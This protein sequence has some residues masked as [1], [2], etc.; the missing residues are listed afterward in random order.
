[1]SGRFQQPQAVLRGILESPRGIVIFALDREYRYLAFNENHARTMKHI[2]GVDIRVGDSMLDLISRPDDREKARRNFDRALGGESFTVIEEYGDERIH[3]NVYQ[4]VYSPICDD[5]ANVIGLTVY[6]TDITE[7]RVAERELE[8]YRNRLEELVKQRTLELE[9][10]HAQLLH[11]QKLESLGVLAGGIAHDFNNLLAV[12]LARTELTTSLLPSEHAARAHVDIV[13]DTALEARMLTKQL[14]GYSGKG[15]FVVQNVDLSEMVEGMSQ[16]LRASI[17][18]SICLKFELGEL[19]AA[20]EVDVTQVRQ[21]LLNLATNAAEAIGDGP[22]VVTIRTRKIDLDENE[23]R[24]A[25]V[26]S[27]VL[28]GPHIALEVEDNGSGMDD[29]IRSKLFDPFF[30]TKFSGRGLGLAA[31][32]GIVTSHRGTILLQTEPGKGSSFTVIFPLSRAAAEPVARPPEANWDSFRGEGTVLVVD[33]ERPVRMVTAEIL[34]SLGYDVLQA[35]GGRRACELYREHAD[36]IR[37]VLLDLTMPE[38]S[39]EETLRELQAI[40]SDVK[41]IVLT[42]YTEDEARLR[43]VRGELAGF[44]AKPFVCNELIATLEAATS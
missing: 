8:D 15:K 2:W 38:M 43:F 29:H 9:A 44:L 6:L 1:M 39:G 24:R 27:A 11:A 16:L 28:P 13:R 7:Q 17:R 30:T 36:R 14:L 37:V 18:K 5:A 4:D 40:R 31:V 22:G 10:A 34:A 32:L 23:L 3:R 21:V 12:I 25:C 26:K 41:V 20:V 33:D 19:P 35:E 42:G